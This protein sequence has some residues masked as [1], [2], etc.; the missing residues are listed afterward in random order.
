[1]IFGA[2]AAAIIFLIIWPWLQID[3]NHLPDDD[4]NE[5]RNVRRW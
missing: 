3:D 4:V 5:I 2:I 1:M